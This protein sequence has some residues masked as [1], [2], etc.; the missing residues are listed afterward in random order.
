[1]SSCLRFCCLY[2]QGL[3]TRKTWNVLP[4]ITEVRNTKAPHVLNKTFWDFSFGRKHREVLTH[5]RDGINPKEYDIVYQTTASPYIA[6]GQVCV[7][8]SALT[9][10]FLM[11]PYLNTE[12]FLSNNVYI[13]ENLERGIMFS[14]FVLINLGIL[15]VIRSFPLRI[16][17]SESRNNF[18]VIFK[19]LFNPWLNR[20]VVCKTG[21][22]LYTPK[23]LQF[24]G[25]HKLLG[26]R[27]YL[28]E[29]YF[30]FPFYYNM[31]L[32]IKNRPL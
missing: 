30:R 26:K 3:I 14:F 21:D 32:G 20:R 13:R 31:L 2:R 27:I 22:L 11:Y 12:I 28:Y 4:F 17:Y 6:L 16:Y 8:V 1:M 29:D 19:Q 23:N 15:Y 18:V 25:D 9:T 7:F 10:V 24:L 5:K